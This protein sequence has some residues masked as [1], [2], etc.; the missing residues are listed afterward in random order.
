MLERESERLHVRM[1]TQL[2][3]GIL[4]L[5]WTAA[6]QSC[7]SCVLSQFSQVSRNIHHPSVYTK[8]N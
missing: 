1:H 5:Q 6:R 4:H 8:G 3:N 7:E 2:E